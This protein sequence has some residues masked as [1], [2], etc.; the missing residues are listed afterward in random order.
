MTAVDEIKARLDI[1]DIVSETVKLRRS[2]RSYTGFCPFHPN[3]K[4]PAFAVFPDSGTWRCFGQCNEG[5]DVF[6]FVMKREG[7]DFA[8]TLKFLAQKAGVT[9]EPMTPERK[10]KEDEFETLRNILEESVKYYQFQLLKTPAGKPALDY[11]LQRGITADSI[12]RFEL[13]YAP[14]SYEA[15]LGHLS[16]KGHSLEQMAEVGLLIER[17]SGG[18]YDKFRNRIMFPIRD[19]AGKMSGF[20][21]RILDPEDIPKFLNSPQTPLFNKSRLLYGLNLAKKAIRDA[22]QVVIVEGYLDVIALHQ[23]GYA[24]CVSPMGTALNE[25]QLRYLKKYTRR[26]VLALDADTAGEKATL[27]GVEVARQAL[28]RE[29]ELTFDPRGLLKHEARLQ[30]DVRVTTLPPGLDPDD[31]V[32]KDSQAWQNIVNHA[33]PIV[34]HVMET[35]AL[36]QDLE[37]AKVKASI[38]AQVTPLIEDVPSAIERDTYRQQL[39]RLLKVDERS[40]LGSQKVRGR[41]RRPGARAT[42]GAGAREASETTSRR[43]VETTTDS[44][45]RQMEKHCL[46]LL[47]KKTDRLYELERALNLAGLDRF[48]AA[49]FEDSQ[50]HELAQLLIK[51]SRQ[52]ALD[53]LEYVNENA[54]DEL[55]DRLREVVEEIKFDEKD[56]ERLLVDLYRTLTTLR[57]IHIN[58]VLNELRY[59][60]EEENK[61]QDDNALQSMILSNTVARGKLDQALAKFPVKR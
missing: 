1:V 27:R 45:T 3:S 41:S 46:A 51:G 48:S 6:K 43:V 39:A 15:L 59:L 24:N 36:G 52:D 8:E 40:L 60:E 13:G 7:W 31:V 2:G 32:L 25:D 56:E 5:G 57:L 21:A 44:R 18:Y 61:E 29:T 14:D 35:L 33:K 12:Q 47:M 16:G 17:D 28:D 37:D 50:N 22:D 9:L 10:E 53:P 11:L 42:G 54:S 55:S 19:T 34:V 38:A 4:T 20:G 49:D 23:C 30:A 26:I 58:Q